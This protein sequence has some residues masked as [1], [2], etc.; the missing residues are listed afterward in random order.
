MDDLKAEDIAEK[1]NGVGRGVIPAECSRLTAFIDVGSSILFWCVVGWTEGFSGAIVDYGTHPKQTLPYFAADEARLNK[2]ADM[3]GLG[4]LNEEARVYAGLRDTIAA[5]CGRSFPRADGKALQQVDVCLV[6]G[7][8]WMKTISQC[9]Q[10]SIYAGRL[11][12]SKG[13]GMG[14]GRAPMQAWPVQPGERKPGDHYRD[15]PNK[16]GIGRLI[17]FDANYWKSFVARALLAPPRSAG[18]LT[19]FGSDAETHRLF[20]D[21]LTSEYRSAEIKA[22]SGDQTEQEL[23]SV[24]PDRRDNHWWDT[25]VGCAVGAAIAGTVWS[26]AV[27]AGEAAQPKTERKR[28]KLSEV[29][30]KKHGGK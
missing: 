24:R 1:V 13:W 6:D 28:V 30:T 7:G 14:S 5:A 2:L 19:L 16:E 15:R 8:K 26:A 4:K 22:K 20:A 27:A 17:T 29:Y 9:C 10:S 18:C 3:P 23:W 25:L 11:R 12:V 21:H